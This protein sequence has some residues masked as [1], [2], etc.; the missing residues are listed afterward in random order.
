[1][2]SKPAVNQN[3][4]SSMIAATSVE[5]SCD[6]T[7]ERKDIRRHESKDKKK[8]YSPEVTLPPLC[9]EPPCFSSG[10]VAKPLFSRPPIL[11]NVPSDRPLSVVELPRLIAQVGPGKAID[12][13]K[14]TEGPRLMASA[15]GTDLPIRTTAESSAQRYTG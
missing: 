10:F 14:W 9:T 1:M 5:R 13:T 2:V 11:Q 4:I 12:D 15:L 6:G 3:V 7:L 8:A